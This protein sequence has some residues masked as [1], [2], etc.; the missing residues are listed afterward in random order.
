MSST[1]SFTILPNTVTPSVGDCRCRLSG[2]DPD[3]AAKKAFVLLCRHYGGGAEE[4]EF[5]F[6]LKERTRGSQG[7][8]FYYV[9][10]RSKLDQPI[11]VGYSDNTFAM[12][13]KIT[14]KCAQEKA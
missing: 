2:S 8:I 11:T 6:A 14:V 7:E 13:Y 1:R 4:L 10:Q 3:V 5:S 9:G 12:N